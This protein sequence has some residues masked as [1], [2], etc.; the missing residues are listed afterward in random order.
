LKG[1]RWF[2]LGAF[3]PFIERGDA[4]TN[5][6]KKGLAIEEKNKKS[7]KDH[8]IKSGFARIAVCHILS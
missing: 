3:S 6:R 4:V 2:N 7:W 1:L 5:R 8:L